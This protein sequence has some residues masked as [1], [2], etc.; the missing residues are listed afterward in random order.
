MKTFAVVFAALAAVTAA[1]KCDYAVVSPKLHSLGPTIATCFEKTGYSLARPSAP[2]TPEQAKAICSKCTDFIQTVTPL[3]WPE[4]E[5][6]MAGKNQTITSYFNSITFPCTGK[7]LESKPK[8]VQIVS[9][10]GAGE[11]CVYAEVGPKLHPLGGVVAKCLDKTGFNAAHPKTMPTADESA[12]ICKEC[13]DLID[14]VAPLTWPECYMELAGKNQTLTAY[15][16]QLT[17]PCGKTAGVPQSAPVA[18]PIAAPANS[19]VVAA[20]S[21]AAVVASS[22][23]ALFL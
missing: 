17:K 8:D 5:L 2:P 16:N 18:A 15:F 4:C 10:K 1:E 7:S 9:S 20:V 3:T 23:A 12:K 21:G 22:V 11:K 19:G 14:A 13:S 6:E